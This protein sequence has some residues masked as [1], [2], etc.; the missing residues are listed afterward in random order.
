[1]AEELELFGF[2]DA[3][4]EVA[5]EVDAF[6]DALEEADALADALWLS[7]GALALE[8]QAARPKV[9]AR[10]RDR[11]AIDFFT[12]FSFL[13]G[14]ELRWASGVSVRVGLVERALFPASSLAPHPGGTLQARRN[15]PHASRSDAHGACGSS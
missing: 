11:T 12:V 8:L 6:A 9:A 2:A 1:M 10:L 5:V 4:A 7:A 15:A 14:S 13:V 3:L